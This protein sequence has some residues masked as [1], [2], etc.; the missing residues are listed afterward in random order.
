[1]PIE[2]LQVICFVGAGNMGCFNAA[3]AALSGYR[4]TLHDV[5]EDNLAQALARCEGIA[6]YLAGTGYCPL[7]T[8]AE[9]LSR[10]STKTDIEEATADADLVS[11]SVFERLDVKRE[12]HGELDRVC[13]D[14]T[15]LTTNSSFL[16][17][18]AIEDAVQRGDRFA[19]MHS[20]MGSPLVD[21]VGSA[22]TSV[23][24]INLLENYVKSIKGVPLVLKKEYPGYVLNA[25]LGPVL[26]M[27]MYLV[28]EEKGSTADVDCAWMYHR[29]APMGP[30][31]ILDLLGLKLVHD[32]WQNRKD[33][34]LIPGLRPGVLSLLGPL[35]ARNEFGMSTGQG[36]YCYPEPGY[37][38]PDFLQQGESASW[39]YEWL[40]MALITSA[41]LVA[42][43]DVA[44]PRTIDMAWKVG[45][46]LDKGPFEL[47]TDRGVS[48][49]T[50]ELEQYE[51]SGR[52][53][54]NK[55]RLVRDY[56][57]SRL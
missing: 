21:I 52:F 37:Q 14:R 4:V 23:A 2:E 57:V 32:S 51:A 50:R 44:D 3:K 48:G 8:V 13:P 49:F 28:V 7:E 56:C 47:L 22:R 18:S 20:Y 31:G 10:I 9:S 42:A 38:D 30:F 11:E 5:S 55:S 34:G 12:V 17:P 29:S 40:E 46:S 6:K 16:L 53:D 26:A 1:M 36:F 27:A 19:A 33:E 54:S 43:A 35:V 25:I 45:T 41:V 24:T 15:I 39:L